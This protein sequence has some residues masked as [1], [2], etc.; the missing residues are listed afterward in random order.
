MC[1]REELKQLLYELLFRV[2]QVAYLSARTQFTDECN[3]LNTR[4]HVINH[5][6]SQSGDGNA[7]F[8][9]IL[10]FQKAYIRYF[11]FSSD[12]YTEFIVP[13][14][15][16]SLALFITNILSR[17]GQSPLAYHT[18]RTIIEFL[19]VSLLF[20]VVHLIS[21]RC[22]L[23]LVPLCVL[24]M[25]TLLQI[26]QNH[27]VERLLVHYKS[28]LAKV[29]KELRLP[30]NID[31]LARIRRDCFQQNFRDPNSLQNHQVHVS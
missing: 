21:N 22:F 17:D 1:S 7:R 16:S 23:T 3:S 25:H 20:V 14:T 19:Q 30:Y 5:D 18:S 28:D 8:E 31:V 9:R 24:H 26:T 13:L 29:I 10:R 11:V 2:N 12:P 4:K 15:S 6:K 27:V